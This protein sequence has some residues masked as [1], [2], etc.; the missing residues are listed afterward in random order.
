MF[1]TMALIHADTPGRLKQNTSY[2]SALNT[3]AQEEKNKYGK[4]CEDLR[5]SFTPL[6]CTVDGCF[7]REV[8]GFLKRIGAKLATKWQK[9]FSVVMNWVKVRI[10]FALICAVDLRIRCTREK[11]HAVGFDNGVGL[12]IFFKELKYHYFIDDDLH[13]INGM[14]VISIEIDTVF[15]I[16]V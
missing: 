4:V 13:C 6:I 15:C 12:G 9:P 7:G 16:I 3:A 8:E 1:L 11:I 2:E 5:A 14:N 10:Q